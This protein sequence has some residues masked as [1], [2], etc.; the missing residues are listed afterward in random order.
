MTTTEQI[1]D[2]HGHEHGEGCGH[3]AF[4]HADHV[5]YAHDG[6]VHRQREGQWAECEVAEH[7]PVDSHE[8][9][10][11]HGCGHTAMPHGDHVDYL[12]DGQRHAA[13]ESHYDQH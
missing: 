1:H 7:M 11:E 4:Q 9:R 2:D 13:H 8:H 5:D 12:H 10:H 3:V 6:D